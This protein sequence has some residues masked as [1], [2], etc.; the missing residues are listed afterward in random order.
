M[1]FFI[2]KCKAIYNIWCDRQAATKHDSGFPS[3]LNPR[4]FPAE[5]WGLISCRPYT[6]KIIGELNQNIFFAL[7]YE[8]TAQYIHK[9]RHT[10]RSF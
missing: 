7:A 6:H 2:K 4:I 10:P 5:H 1:T 9:R 3:N 8:N